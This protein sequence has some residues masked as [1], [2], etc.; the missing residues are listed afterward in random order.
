MTVIKD[1]AELEVTPE[2]PI[3]VVTLQRWPLEEDDSQ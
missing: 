3:Q 2:M 1:V